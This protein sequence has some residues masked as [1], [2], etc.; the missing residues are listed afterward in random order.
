MS[1][2]VVA[3]LIAV[4]IAF[5][6]IKYFDSDQKTASG[7]SLVAVK[8]PTLSGVAVQGEQLFSENCAACHGPNASGRDGI[9]PPLIHKIYEPGHHGDAAFL[10]A[11]T[12][13]VR[14]HHWS[15]GNMPVVE[16]VN[17]DEVQKIVEYVRFV[18]RANGI[19]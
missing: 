16:N 8:V 5:F 11:A 3:I 9:G 19:N 13:G 2:P 6:A 14:A 12:R 15:F 1:R 7:A 10:L 4:L 17:E 18:Q